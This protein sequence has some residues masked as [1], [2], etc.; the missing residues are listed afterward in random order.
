MIINPDKFRHRLELY[1]RPQTPD[2]VGGITYNNTL[3]TSVWGSIEPKQG[4]SYLYKQNINEQP[5]TTIFIRYIDYLTSEFWV[6]YA[7]KTFRTNSSYTNDPL[8]T[9]K[10]YRILEVKNVFQLDRFLEL[11]CEEYFQT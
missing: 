1:Q 4:S 7:P 10:T 6:V 3:V 5:T 2:L 8:I 9:K 11:K